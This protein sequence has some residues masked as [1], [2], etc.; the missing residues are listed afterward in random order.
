MTIYE[1]S[2]KELTEFVEWFNKH[3]GFHPIII[4]GWAVYHYNPYFESKD[5]DVVF[6]FPRS[7]WDQTSQFQPCSQFGKR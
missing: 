3:K 6:E 2:H 7:G 4:G 1:E 5:I